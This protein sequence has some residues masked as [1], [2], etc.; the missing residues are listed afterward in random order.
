MLWVRSIEKGENHCP[1][2]KY[3]NKPSRR[4]SLERGGASGRAK[5]LSGEGQLKLLLIVAAR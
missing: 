4:D 2:G 5:A 3:R 1:N